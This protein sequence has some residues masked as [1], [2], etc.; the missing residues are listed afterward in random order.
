[1]QSELAEV[2][3]R[4]RELQVQLAAALQRRQGDHAPQWGP[5]VAPQAVERPQWPLRSDPVQPQRPRQEDDAPQWGP[6]VAS[7]AVERPQWPQ[8]PDPVQ[9]QRPYAVHDVERPQSQQL[10][11]APPEP[12]P[13]AHADILQEIRAS[14]SAIAAAVAPAVVHADAPARRLQLPPP[15]QG[16]E[17]PM[18]LQPQLLGGPPQPLQFVFNLQT[19]PPQRR[20]RPRVRYE[21][22]FD[23]ETQL[24]LWALLR[25]AY[26]QQ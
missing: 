18:P 11:Q 10:R 4:N 20:G 17:P 15:A 25:G 19:P 7:Q 26:R 14:L 24:D 23:A 16:M 9:P 21:D 13:N 3:A 8:R 1:M 2:I 5:S 22:D 12:T 6:S